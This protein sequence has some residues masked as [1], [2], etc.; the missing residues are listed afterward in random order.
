MATINPPRFSFM[1][2]NFLGREKGYKNVTGFGEGKTSIAEFYSPEETYPERI[3]RLF[4][5]IAALGFKGVDLWNA[6]CHPDWATTKHIEAVRAASEKHGLQLVSMAGSLPG[7]LDEAELGIRLCRD[8]GCPLF[9]GGTRALPE[10]AEAFNKLLVQYGVRL[11]FENHPQEK[12]PEDVLNAISHGK[13]PS[14]G[15]AL[16]TGWWGTHNYPVEEA[17][18]EL[19]DWIFLVHLK[20]VQK[21]GAHE[22]ARWDEGC[23][24]VRAALKQLKRTGYQGWISLEYEP[25]DHDPSEDCREYLQLATRWWN[26]A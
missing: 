15:V 3:D 1:S 13:F 24:D 25:L 20:N 26:E 2:A 22:A 14:I 11:G 4:S 8:L 19:R 7:N 18:N 5:E 23:V 10:H 17:I 21:P 12:T 9:G 6:H 16:D